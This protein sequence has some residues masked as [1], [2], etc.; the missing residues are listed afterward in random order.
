VQRATLSGPL[1]TIIG[2]AYFVDLFVR[3]GPPGGSDT[4]AMFIHLHWGGFYRLNFGYGAWVGL[5]LLL[6]LA[7]G[8]AVRLEEHG[9][10]F[11]LREGRVGPSA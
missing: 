4:P 8:A 2:I 3:W 1:F 11:G 7:A 6:A 10:R 5:F 9:A